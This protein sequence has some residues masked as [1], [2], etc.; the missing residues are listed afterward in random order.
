[1]RSCQANV[2]VSDLRHLLV[3]KLRPKAPE[4]RRPHQFCAVP[5]TRQ[6]DP[7]A[8][9]VH[10]A[11]REQEVPRPLRAGAPRVPR[12]PQLHVR[13]GRGLQADPQGR[14]L[15]GPWAERRRACGTSQDEQ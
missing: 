1:M 6:V 15:Q 2:G 11:G 14:R 5:D 13:P 3:H 8:D 10:E 7:Q 4:L 12:P 9:R